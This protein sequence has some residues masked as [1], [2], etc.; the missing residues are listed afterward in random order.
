[1]NGTAEIAATLATRI[2]EAAQRRNHIDV[3]LFP[4]FTAL[5]VARE[6]LSAPN[7]FLGAQDCFWLP[8]GAY[9]GQ[10]SPEMLRDAGCGFCIVGHSEKRG[11]FGSSEMRRELIDYFSDND[12]TVSL[13]TKALLASGIKPIVCVGETE[14]E[15]SVGETA[16]VVFQQ[17]SCALNGIDAESVV[18]IAFAYEPVWAIGTGNVC[19]PEEANRVCGNIREIIADLF[20]TDRATTIRILYGGSVT[21]DNARGLLSEPEIDGALVGGA[22]LDKNEFTAILES[23]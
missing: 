9:T 10:V 4:P 1:M 20:A 22:S 8:N 17:L 23:A 6:A 15:R 18:N 19:Q 11:R 21:A 13:K 12:E 7:C 14:Y 5:H 16:S 3:A 2:N